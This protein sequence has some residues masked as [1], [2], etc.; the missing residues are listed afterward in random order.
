MANFGEP[1]RE[2]TTYYSP[3]VKLQLLAK[4]VLNFRQK[5]STPNLEIIP[6]NAFFREIS[7]QT[8]KE[9]P[10]SMEKEIPIVGE[11]LMNSAKVIKENAMKI[12]NMVGKADKIEPGDKELV[13]FVSEMSKVQGAM[14]VDAALSLQDRTLAN[15]NK[16]LI[17]HE[18]SEL[19]GQTFPLVIRTNEQ[20]QRKKVASHPQFLNVNAKLC[21]EI[22]RESLLILDNKDWI[23]GPIDPSLIEDARILLQYSDRDEFK[24]ETVEV[25]E[26]LFKKSVISAGGFKNDVFTNVLKSII[27]NYYREK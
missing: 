5:S 2:V 25:I 23:N 9:L 8:I 16:Q 18:A 14:V 22:A 6:G 10:K 19:I 11:Y 4:D 21:S 1:V 24:Y 15:D 13:E 26:R 7:P 20:L 27:E 3:V 12:I 17:L